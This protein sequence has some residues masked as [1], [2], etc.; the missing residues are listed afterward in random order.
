MSAQT[1]AGVDTGFVR[2]P[3]GTLNSMTVGGKSYYYL[4]DALGSV[5]ALTDASGNKV[6]EYSYS[7][8][9]VTRAATTEQVPQ[10]YRF[11]GAYQDPTGLYKMGA[12]YYD[13]N[14]GRFTQVDPS[15]KETNPYLYASG[16]Y[17]NH[18]DPNGL[19]NFYGLYE[20]V[21]TV[22]NTLQHGFQGNTAAL[23]GDL[24]GVATGI[25]IESACQFVAGFAGVPTEGVGAV[26][27]ETGCL[28][29]SSYA[30]QW[31]SG[32]VQSAMS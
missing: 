12:R 2:E 16:D 7:P 5:I 11:A 14:I 20:D 24:A 4:T 9:G 25:A 23:W 30:G 31:V 28:V 26:A 15:G 22:G 21:K 6:D 13:T 18:T 1:T 29:A 8:R 3:A 17:I 32:Q 10:P 19:L 27:V